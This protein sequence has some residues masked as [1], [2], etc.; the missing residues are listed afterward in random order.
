MSKKTIWATVPLRNQFRGIDGWGPKKLK[1]S[2]SGF[3]SLHTH[4]YVLRR[5]LVAKAELY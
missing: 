4:T 3:L 5:N 2:A 1:N